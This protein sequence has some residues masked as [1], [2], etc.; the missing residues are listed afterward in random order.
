[1]LA[2]HIYINGQ[3]KEAIDLYV[4]AFN[5]SVEKII[6]DPDQEHLIIHAEIL[7]HNQ[8]LMMNDFGGNTGFSKSGGYQLSVTFHNENELKDV[9]LILKEG[10]TTV[11]P[12][13]PTDYSPCVVRFIDKYDVRWALW[14]DTELDAGLEQ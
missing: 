14:V 12:I 2:T 6:Q 9:Y 10:S 11:L 13:Q 8:L 1:M 3:C 7:I 4:K 5:A